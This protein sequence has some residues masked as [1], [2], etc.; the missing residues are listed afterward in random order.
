[1]MLKKEILPSNEVSVIP[2]KNLL[3]VQNGM[4]LKVAPHL[5]TAAIEPS[6][7]G[8]KMKAGPALNA[9]SK[10]TSAGLKYM[11]QQENHAVVR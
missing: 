3:S 8:K 7:F 11:V 4:A 5:S 6:H 10:A 9:F 1:M 2:I